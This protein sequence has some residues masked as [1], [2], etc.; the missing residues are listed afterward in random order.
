MERATETPLPMPDLPSIPA[1]FEAS[2]T[3]CVVTAAERPAAMEP[4]TAPA[5]A[6]PTAAVAAVMQLSKL[7]EQEVPASS[8][9]AQQRHKEE[10][11]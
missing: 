5:T 4:P 9:S 1:I 10:T 7:A 11:E 3:F 8:S 2:L 6:P